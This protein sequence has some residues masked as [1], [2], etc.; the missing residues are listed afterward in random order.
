MTSLA[1]VGLVG[2]EPVVAGAFFDNDRHTQRQGFAHAAFDKCFD[3]FAFGFPH[4]KHQF[5]MHLKDHFR[6]QAK[7][8]HFIENPDHRYFD[9][10]GR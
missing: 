4:I 7:P 1:A 5:V 3:L 6:L 10:I 2:F 8:V 9:H